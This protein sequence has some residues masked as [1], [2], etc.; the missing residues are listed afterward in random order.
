[1]LIC[2]RLPAQAGGSCAALRASETSVR[3]QP[4]R[5]EQTAVSENFKSPE[6]QTPKTLCLLEWIFAGLE[7]VLH[8]R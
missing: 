7:A 1:M 6:E 4:G 8:V 5:F 2:A 3:D